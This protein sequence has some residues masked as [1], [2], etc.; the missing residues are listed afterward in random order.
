MIKTSAYTEDTLEIVAAGLALLL[1]Q[2]YIVTNPFFDEKEIKQYLLLRRQF[3][4]DFIQACVDLAQAFEDGEFG[5]AVKP[6]IPALRAIGRLTVRQEQQALRQMTRAFRGL[7]NLRYQDVDNP[8]LMRLIAMARRIDNLSEASMMDRQIKEFL[9]TLVKVSV[10]PARLKTLLRKVIKL[11][12]PGAF[13]GDSANPGEWFD[14]P[15]DR[16]QAL[17][18]TAEKTEK[19]RDEIYEKYKDDPDARQKA[20]VDTARRLQKIQNVAGVNLGIIKKDQAVPL[21]QLLKKESKMESDGPTEFVRVKIEA[22]LKDTG[23][24]FSTK[25]QRKEGDPVP[26]EIGKILTN[27]KKA[28]TF[29]TMQRC[30]KD[31]VDR[32]VLSMT[33]IEDVDHIISQ[34]G[35]NRAVREGKP[36]AP[37]QFEP[38]TVEQFQVDHDTGAIEFDPEYSEDERK[39]LLG[40]VSRAI[41]DLEGVYGKGFCGKHTKKLKFRFNKDYSGTASASY[42][43]VDGNQWQPIVKFGPEYQGLLAH[44]LSHY[45]EDLLSAQIMRHTDPEGAKQNEA[46]GWGAGFGKIFGNTG[47]ALD[48]LGPDGSLNKSRDNIGKVIP[49]FLE[50]VDT[51]LATPDYKRWSDKLGSAYDTALPGAIKKLTGMNYYDLPK[52]HPY[53]GLIDRAQYRSDLPPEL[54]KA[55]QALYTELMGGDA[56]KL[57]YYNS[58]VEIWARMC[59]QYVY[60]KLIDG[61][62]SNPWLT[63]MSYDDDVFMDEKTFD[64]QLR[65]VM[66]KLFSRLKGHSLLASKNA[67]DI[68]VHV[69]ERFNQQ[70]DLEEEDASEL[71]FAMEFDTEQQKKNYVE[72]HDV[73]PGTPLV[74]KKP[75]KAPDKKSPKA[76]SPFSTQDLG[77]T[78]AAH[79]SSF[80]SISSKYKDKTYTSERAERAASV[81]KKMAE[82]MSSLLKHELGKMSE[83]EK[84]LLQGGHELGQKFEASLSKAEAKM[85]ANYLDR[86]RTCAGAYDHKG[87]GDSEDLDLTSCKLQGMAGAFGFTGSLAPED[88]EL[89][90]G[91]LVTKA[92]AQGANDK[93]LLAHAKKMYDYQQAYFEHAGIKELTLYRGVKFSDTDKADEGTKVQI[94][95]REMSSFTMD[96][97]VARHFGRVVKFKV[98][99]KNIFASPLVRP[100][101]ASESSPDTHMD[102]CFHEAEFIVMGASDLTGETLGAQRNEDE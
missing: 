32:K 42:T 24:Y 87:N 47:V 36:L 97:A 99:V 68:A 77:Q 71:R 19:E 50:F 25:K 52:D 80:D 20:Y 72:K 90:K 62:V 1:A 35:K 92:R 26:R 94:E 58:A 73:K 56:R 17:R 2:Q 18:E 38:K 66:D 9:T 75:K 28:R 7:K 12:A 54:D 49:E 60:N 8:K 39:E 63:Q 37:L 53:Y 21:E 16:Q 84:V 44:E 46:R 81:D 76:D 65:P 55:A 85:H 57:S 48:L 23:T 101:F 93:K 34:A 96:P 67:F 13:A 40:R 64:E 43:D 69:L 100:E 74:V 91:G 78:I 14:M 15:T 4:G 41:S 45:L 82:Q 11:P 22:Y 95:S 5:N 51:V 98:P 70:S 89:D 30:I 3:H 59:E 31:A 83:S 88:K 86:W 79:K 33:S 61:G 6:A 29:S 27:I 102:G 10:L